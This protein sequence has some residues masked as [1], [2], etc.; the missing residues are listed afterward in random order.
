MKI[1][2]YD[3]LLAALDKRLAFFKEV[4]TCVS[5]HG[6]DYVMYHPASE[7]EVKAIFVKRLNGEALQF[8]TALLVWL[9]KQYNKLGW[10]M[11]LHYG[12]RRDLN[13]KIFKA[14]G[15]DAGIDSINDTSIWSVSS[16]LK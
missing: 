11:Q 15:P 5:D 2:N 16:I 4:G 14:L 12:V 13:E 7:D 1:N 8:K 10:V 9:G 3:A 6:L